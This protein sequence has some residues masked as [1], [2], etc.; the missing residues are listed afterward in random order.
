MESGKF[1]FI[2]CMLVL[3]ALCGTGFAGVI[4]I[5]KTIS[6]MCTEISDILPV[7][8]MLMII[9]AGVVYAAG[10]IMGAE[11]RA[12][13]TQWATAMLIGAVMGILII[14]VAPSVLSIMMQCQISCNSGAVIIGNLPPC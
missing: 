14:T 11:T 3:F 9:G 2:A 1:A 5:G 6:T 13:A 4:N 10:Q 12:R 7:V 8:C